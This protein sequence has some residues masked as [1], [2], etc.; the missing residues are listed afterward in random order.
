MGRWFA[1]FLFWAATAGATEVPFLSGPL[2]DEA[3]WLSPS[4]SQKVTTALKALNTSDRVQMAVLVARSLQGESIEGYAIAVAEKWKLGTEEKDN[5]LLLVIVPSK[6]RMRL[7]V[8]YGL[9][10][11]LPDAF[12]KRIVADDMAPYFRAGR[13]A[14][15]V[16]AAIAS[17]ARYLNV[18]LGQGAATLYEPR[19]GVLPVW[20]F[21]LLFFGCLGISF[22]SLFHM[23]GRGG[24][25]GYF[26]SGYGGWGAGGRSTGGSFGGGFGGGGFGGGGGGFGGGGASGGW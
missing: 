25:T 7:E 13:K 14:D 26:G 3:Q 23:G 5:G 20:L 22:F 18:D 9:E 8:G 19:K 15:G 2:V 11:D 24:A 12:A 17:V 1:L 10:G 16:L 6:R 21:F 4:E